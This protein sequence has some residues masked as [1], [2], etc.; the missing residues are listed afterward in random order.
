MIVPILH[1]RRIRFTFFTR[2][3]L[4]RRLQMALVGVFSAAALVLAVVGL[5]GVL[6]YS[7]SLRK[8]ELSVRI[9]L[10]AQLSDILRLI[11]GSGLKIA[12]IGLMI[13]LMA[14]LLLSRLLE[15]ML[16]GVSAVDPISFCASVAVLGF[17]ASV[18]CLV[19]ALR[20]TQIDPIKTLRE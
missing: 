19:P 16:F 2:S 5:Y 1:G 18:A 15:S 17:A 4:S 10:G 13:G 12:G 11:V 6:S 14:A 7:V 3:L 20:A 9:A 8:R